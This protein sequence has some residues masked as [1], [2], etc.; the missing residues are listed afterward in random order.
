MTVDLFYLQ[1]EQEIWAHEYFSDEIT[2]IADAQ[3]VTEWRVRR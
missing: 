1:I 3:W 2:I